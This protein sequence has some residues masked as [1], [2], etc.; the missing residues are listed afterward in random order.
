MF[1]KSTLG[2]DEMSTSALHHRRATEGIDPRTSGETEHVQ[3]F[4]ENKYEQDVSCWSHIA[5][6]LQDSCY[7]VLAHT[8]IWDT[9]ISNFNPARIRAIELM[10]IQ[11]NDRVL[12]I[13][14]GSGADF[15]FLPE[16]TNK[17]ALRAFDFSPA[18]VQ[19][20]KLKARQL[21]IPEENCF[22]GDA[23]KMPYTHERFEKILFPLSI[24][25]IPNPSLALS[26]AERVLAPGGKIV[27][28]DKFRADDEDLSWTRM[29]LNAITKCV[30]AD[31]NRNLGSMLAPISALKIVHYESLEGKVNGLFSVFAQHYKVAVVVRDI[32]Y[33]EK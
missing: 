30:F 27:I 5:Q 22:I 20:C 21:D 12:F 11:S 3:N 6:W 13:G 14:E 15:E 16:Q 7:Q 25:S 19:Q 4:T 9:I 2:G 32:D 17:A 23:Q 28:F 10:D 26:E 18:M 29:A 31:I 33:P 24:A 8:S 1:K